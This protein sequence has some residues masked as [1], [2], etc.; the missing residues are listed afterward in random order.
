MFYFSLFWLAST[1]CLSVWLVFMLSHFVYL[2]VGGECGAGFWILLTTEDRWFHPAGVGLLANHWVVLGTWA[3]FA[4][5]GFYVIEQYYWF[6]VVLPSSYGCIWEVTLGT[7]D[8]YKRGSSFLP[9]VQRVDSTVQW[10]NYYP[11][12][13]PIDFDSTYFM[14]T[15]LSVWQYYLT[16]ELYCSIILLLSPCL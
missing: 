1:E 16:F 9:V 15:D 14:D 13:N 12:D 4:A 10:I 6:M 8:W 11:L 2:F 5:N 7:R 3:P